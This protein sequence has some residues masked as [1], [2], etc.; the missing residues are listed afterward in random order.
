MY[1]T[2]GKK[3][4][5]YICYIVPLFTQKYLHNYC[6][7][8]TFVHVSKITHLFI[9]SQFTTYW[10]Q[11][12]V[13]KWVSECGH[14]CIAQ[15]HCA[16]CRITTGMKS[17]MKYNLILIRFQATS[18]YGF[19]KSDFMQTTNKKKKMFCLASQSPF[20]D[21]VEQQTSDLTQYLSSTPLGTWFINLNH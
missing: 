3:I 19:Q 4:S 6:L 9:H 20:D 1:V 18:K 8:Y 10:M 15:L 7:I 11:H 17:D 5:W 13:V 2:I 14:S 12:T 21:T 16:L